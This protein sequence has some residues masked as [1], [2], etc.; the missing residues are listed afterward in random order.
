LFFVFSGYYLSKSK[1]SKQ[2]WKIAILPIIA[3]AVISGLRFGR[4]IDYNIYYFIYIGETF[5]STEFLFHIIVSFFNYLDIPYYGFVLFCSTFLIVSF[6]FLLREFKRYAFF[7]L[8]LFLVIGGIENFIRWYLAFSFIL[9]AIAFLMKSRYIVAIMLAVSSC[10][11][12]FG[13]LIPLFTILF[14]YVFVNKKIIDPKISIT[15]FLISLFLSSID[16]LVQLASLLNYINFDFFPERA[17]G[18]I[19]EAESIARGERRTGIAEFGLIRKI[20]FFILYVFPIYFGAKYFHEN[21]F[22]LLAKT[23]WLYNLAVFTIIII[24]LF[25]LVEFFNRTVWLLSSFSYI[26]IG[27]STFIAYKQ[28]FF[29]K[30]TFLFL[31]V[32]FLFAAY[33]AVTE[34][35]KPAK[36]NEMLFIWDAGVRKYLPY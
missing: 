31:L 2:Y 35:L 11:V 16:Q 7:I 32:S 15:L 9:I 1:T 24:P 21:K 22:G 30:K 18:Y 23:M 19:S 25:S 3:F 20:R 12:H 33:P 29:N 17:Q 5:E 13:I 28:R 10:F 27:I 14:F 26:I 36:D 4:E 34:S 8:P 6:L